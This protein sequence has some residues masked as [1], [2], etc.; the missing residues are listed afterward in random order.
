M[1]VEQLQYGNTL[2]FWVAPAVGRVFQP[3]LQKGEEVSLWRDETTASY[4]LGQG[5]TACQI[6]AEHDHTHTLGDLCTTNMPRI[7]WLVD[8]K[9]AKTPDRLLLQVHKFPREL[10]SLNLELAV[11]ET[12]VEQAR[13]LHPRAAGIEDVIQ[14]LAD[15]CLLPAHGDGT[16]IRA[17]LSA[18]KGDS[19]DQTDAFV[20]HGKTLRLF[21]RRVRSAAAEDKSPSPEFLSVDRITRTRGDA[22]RHPIILASGQLHFCDR[23]AVGRLR[24]SA[25]AELAALAQSDESFLATWRKYGELEERII[26]ERARSIGVIAYSSFEFLPDGTI[27]FDLSSPG[28]EQKLGQLESGDVLEVN[29]VAPRVIGQLDL[30]WADCEAEQSAKDDQASLLVGEVVGNILPASHCV[31]LKPDEESQQPPL[32]GLMFLSIMGDRTRLARRREAQERILSGPMPQL[33]LLLEGADAPI[34]RHQRTP[35]LTR[36]VREKIF[37]ENPPTPRQEKA[38]SVALNTPDIALIQGPPGTGK[39]TVVRAIVERLNEIADNSSGISG[40]FL[41]SGFQHDAVENAISKLSVNSLPAIKFGTRNNRDEYEEAEQRIYDW[42]RTAAAEIRQKFSGIQRSNIQRHLSEL[43]RSYVLAPGDSRRTADMLGQAIAL[44]QTEIPRVLLDE[45]SDLRNQLAAEV[46]IS[47]EQNQDTIAIIRAIRAIRTTP[48]AFADDGH[49]TARCLLLRLRRRSDI[50][51]DDL[52]LLENVSEARSLIASST[53]ERLTQL[54]RRLLHK[55]VP[56][57]LPFSRPKVRQQVMELLGRLHDALEERF[58]KSYSAADAA[59]GEFVD[60]MENDFAAVKRAVMDYTPVYAA[61]CQQ[62]MHWSVAEAK[63]GQG[64]EYDTVLVDEAARSNPLDLFIP[65]TQASRRIILVGDHRQLPHMIDTQIEKELEHAAKDDD[66]SALEKTR[67]IIHESLFQ[68]LFR[69]MQAREKKDGVNRTVTLDVQY[70]MHPVLGAFVSDQF[71]SPYG[72]GF[73]SEL[74]ADNFEHHL[75]GYKAQPTAWIHVPIE[76]G[77]EQSGQSKA[78]PAEATAIAAEVNRLMH[79]DA[80]SSLTFGVITFYSAQVAELGRSL[81]SVDL[82]VPDESGG[83]RVA[84]RYS[85]RLRVGTVDAFQ[86]REFDVV[87]LSI[88]RCNR[89]PDASERDRRRKYGHLM[90]PNRLCVSMSRQKRLLVVVGDAGMI[91][92]AHAKEAIGPLEAFYCLCRREGAVK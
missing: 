69:L 19:E 86:G 49:H 61:T 44:L 33:G 65:M 47:P 78:R 29:N 54:R 38:I 50:A 24:A 74:P 17:F 40:R 48:A 85:R 2:Q 34:P 10:S 6:A 57:D 37:P 18:G 23:T 83:F 82:M 55:F 32:S 12:I 45:V 88:V 81:S 91:T 60:A 30:T 25:R 7:V 31:V 56:R 70:R 41:I 46:R 90:L 89:L 14:W 76:R 8:W 71:Y 84:D 79:T 26:L 3:G 13:K 73:A 36:R 4:L 77:K 16:A 66:E 75:E 64:I 62:S 15:Q 21:I 87:F 9:P 92:S 11:D 28:V 53:L 72:E 35:A 52:R 5:T 68:Y 67:R 22:N 20:L 43:I 42:S 59:T 1:L 63:G 80:A 51:D 27:R 58:R 39:T